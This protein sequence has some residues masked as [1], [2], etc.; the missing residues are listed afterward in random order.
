MRGG[1]RGREGGKDACEGSIRFMVK[2]VIDF[3]L[4]KVTVAVIK[5]RDVSHSTKTRYVPLRGVQAIATATLL[6]PH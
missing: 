3:Y 4:L 5:H 2:G 6:S 1:R